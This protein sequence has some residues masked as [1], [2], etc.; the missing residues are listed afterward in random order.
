MFRHFLRLRTTSAK[1][2]LR[3]GAL[4]LAKWTKSVDEWMRGFVDQARK[5]RLA[6]DNGPRNTV[7]AKNIVLV[8]LNR[9]WNAGRICNIQQPDESVSLCG[10]AWAVCSELLLAV[11]EMKGSLAHSLAGQ[12]CYKRRTTN[13]QKGNASRKSV[14]GRARTPDPSELIPMPDC[15]GQSYSAGAGV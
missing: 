2:L 11:S 13:E 3:G 15:R 7:L 9:E 8:E 14:R 5:A 12:E 6:V 1:C 10:L 4:T